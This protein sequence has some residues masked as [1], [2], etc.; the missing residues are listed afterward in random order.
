MPAPS[1]QVTGLQPPVLPG[2]AADQRLCQSELPTVE[3]CIDQAPLTLPRPD[4]FFAALSED[5]PVLANL[6]LR[7]K[8]FGA[9]EW[10]GTLA[11]PVLI[12]SW[13]RAEPHLRRQLERWA[14]SGCIRG[15][16]LTNPVVQ[17]KDL[18][19][20]PEL[21]GLFGFKRGFDL[22]RRRWMVGF[23]D[24][25]HGQPV[26]KLCKTQ[27]INFFDGTSAASPR[28]LVAASETSA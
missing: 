21:N 26:A 4:A 10:R 12:A 8:M 14:E 7:S 5:F 3:L 20:K 17:L 9:W 22:Q 23:H 25:G 27:N 19:V 6:Q 24:P 13:N 16:H 28:V 18:V 11:T 2:N 15:A 1:F